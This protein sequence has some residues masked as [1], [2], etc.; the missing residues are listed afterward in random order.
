M[1]P[2]ATTTIRVERP[3]SV[4]TPAEEDPYGEGYDDEAGGDTNDWGKSV[5]VAS[6]V[7]ATIGQPGGSEIN[8][9]GSQSVVTHKVN[10]DPC[11]M[12]YLDVVVDESTGERFDVVW[13]KSVT[14]LGLDHVT[15]T[16]KMTAGRV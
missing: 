7:R 10:C 5:V 4:S 14:G 6:G 8:A 2:I 3:L 16:L 13:S 15:A 1:I 11:D 12:T 9:G